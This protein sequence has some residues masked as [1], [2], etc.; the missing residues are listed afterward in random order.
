MRDMYL[1][2]F[3]QLRESVETR[4]NYGNSLRRGRCRSMLNVGCDDIEKCHL[5]YS[6][7]VSLVRRESNRR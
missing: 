5:F 4:F 7:L 2:S 6:A 1:M 3:S